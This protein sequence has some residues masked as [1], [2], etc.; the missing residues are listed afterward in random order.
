[1][2]A[3]LSCGDR[4]PH[5]A[6]ARADRRTHCSERAVIHIGDALTP[7]RAPP[8]DVFREPAALSNTENAEQA[9][10]TASVLVGSRIQ[11]S[12]APRGTQPAG[13]RA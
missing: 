12:W 2:Y 1:M 8:G 10:T 5:P 6:R 13:D 9:A 7:T 11:L 4:P 3:W